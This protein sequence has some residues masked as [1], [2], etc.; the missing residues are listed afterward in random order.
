[1][2]TEPNDAIAGAFDELVERAV[3]TMFGQPVPAAA[4]ARATTR[5]WVWQLTTSLPLRR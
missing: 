2:S 3:C 5:S 1:M 4:G